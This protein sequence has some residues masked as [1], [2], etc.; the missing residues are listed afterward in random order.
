M[1]IIHCNSMLLAYTIKIPIALAFGE[2]DTQIMCKKF[3]IG[4]FL[5]KPSHL[6]RSVWIGVVRYLNLVICYIVIYISGSSEHILGLTNFTVKPSPY[7][8]N[9]VTYKKNEKCC[10]YREL[11][12]Y[13]H[14]KY[15]Y[16]FIILFMHEDNT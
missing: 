9:F 15:A 7:D 13:G 12:N 3:A 16:Y 6:V 5:S 8:F 14:I 11:I 10:T 1:Y 4:Q 2:L